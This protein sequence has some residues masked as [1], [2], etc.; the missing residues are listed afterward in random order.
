MRR[1]SGNLSLQWAAEEI[2]DVTVY[3]N[4]RYYRFA[5]PPAACKVTGRADG[6]AP[7]VATGPKGAR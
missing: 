6:T 3:L 2:D 1:W 4:G 5:C 7:L